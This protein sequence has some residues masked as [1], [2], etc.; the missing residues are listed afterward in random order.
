MR[1][2]IG[3]AAV[4]LALARQDLVAVRVA[5][6]R[7]TADLARTPDASDLLRRWCRVARA[8]ALIAMGAPERARALV[9]EMRPGHGLTGSWE[10][11]C[12]A[13]IHFADGDLA[14]AAEVLSPLAAPDPVALEPAVEAHLMLAVIADRMRRDTAA[15][16]ALGTALDLAEAEDIRRPFVAHGSRLTALMV[17]Y[18]HVVG[19]HRD[20]VAGLRRQLDPAE[21]RSVASTSIAEPIES[22]TEREMIVLR[23]LPT[24]LKAGEIGADLYVSVNT[25]K[26][27]LR[28]IYRKLDVTN[29]REAV[30]RSRSLGLL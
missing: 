12:A 26:A 4:M 5:D 20:F 17:T 3:A 19:G 8:N 14:V 24:M 16:T 1:L 13:Q 7:L 29:R 11:N 6:A 15:V 21:L 25:V 27:H 28:S 22:L 23:Y 2:A 18:Q 9:R 30:E 10:R